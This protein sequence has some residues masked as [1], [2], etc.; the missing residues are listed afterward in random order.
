MEEAIKDII[1]AE[2][3]LEGRALAD[4]FSQLIALSHFA[5]MRCPTPGPSRQEMR[6]YPDFVMNFSGRWA[7]AW[8]SRGDLWLG[9]VGSGC[10]TMVG[11][12]GCVLAQRLA[13]SV[14][15]PAVVCMGSGSD[16]S[17]L[18]PFAA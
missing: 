17:Y 18:W 10:A 12:R 6:V 4:V 9:A 7:L 16:K 8:D 5:G 3:L 13:E 15:A 1:P 2:G 14:L 11:A